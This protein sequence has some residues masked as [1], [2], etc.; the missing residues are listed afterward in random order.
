M[1][2]LVGRAGEMLAYVGRAARLMFQP[3]GRSEL[4][5]VSAVAG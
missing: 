2:R 3:N 4:D 1:S 5:F